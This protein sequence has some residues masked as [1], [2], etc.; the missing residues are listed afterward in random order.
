MTEKLTLF[1]LLHF[2][3][4]NEQEKDIFNFDKTV[5]NRL[6]MS[7]DKDLFYLGG[8]I[9]MK[10]NDLISLKSIQKVRGINEKITYEYGAPR[11]SSDLTS[12]YTAQKE[13]EF[14][15]NMIR[16]YILIMEAREKERKSLYNYPYYY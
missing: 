2:T 14:I 9:K 15:E 6:I 1:N 3:P 7:L 8:H 10:H 11:N 12:V 13:L 16:S 4:L 5:I